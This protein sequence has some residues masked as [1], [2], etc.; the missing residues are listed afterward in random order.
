MKKTWQRITALLVIPL[1]VLSAIVCC[2]L[3]DTVQ[4]EEHSPS[5]H[6]TAGSRD[7]NDASSHTGKQSGEDCCCVPVVGFLAS[8]M[9]PTIKLVI[10]AFSDMENILPPNGIVNDVFSNKTLTLAYQGPPKTAVHPL[11]IYLQ[12]SDLRL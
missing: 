10:T 1:L 9:A 5:C 2:C 3:T 12:I 11:P 6:R 4:A 8:T 7:S